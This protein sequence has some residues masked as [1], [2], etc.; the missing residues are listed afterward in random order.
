VLCEARYRYEFPSG[1]N[2]LRS[3]KPWLSAFTQRSTLR[4]TSDGGAVI[5]A[6]FG[7]QVNLGAGSVVATSGANGLV[8]K[9]DKN[10]KPLWTRSMVPS[11]QTDVLI[12]VGLSVDKEDSTYVV[13]MGGPLLD[14]N[15]LA[16][17][18]HTFATEI[19]VYKFSKSG[20]PLW[21]KAFSTWPGGLI[22]DTAVDD[23][24]QL[25]IA[26]IAH[27]QT[28]FGGGPLDPFS[29]TAYRPYLLK[30]DA[31]GRY[32]TDK[33][34][35]VYQLAHAEDRIVYV[36][37]GFQGFDL[38]WV[39]FGQNT[40]RPETKIT[41]LSMADLST[42][43][44]KPVP[45][46]STN[47]Y[48]SLL[49]Y[50]DGRALGLTS[51]RIHEN[52][53][54][55]YTRGERWSVRPI[56]ADG[57]LG[58]EVVFLEEKDTVRLD[59]EAGVVYPN[60]PDP[61]LDDATLNAQGEIAIAGYYY[62]PWTIEQL[63]TSLPHDLPL[64]DGQPRSGLPFVMKLGAQYDLQWIRKPEWGER[65]ELGGIGV[66]ASGDVWLHGQAQVSGDE[67]AAWVERDMVIT[68]LRGAP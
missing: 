54:T 33:P 48:Q 62:G 66:D 40:P 47:W 35:A 60:F 20:E 9:Y 43:W 27:A 22:M 50:P 46:D 55:T 56:A 37:G 34:N 11:L 36:D 42:T 51:E 18:S 64:E 65:P 68:K 44:A 61:W 26:G 25:F 12:P 63:G 21:R 67:G 10:C 5:V 17:V 45:S 8:H 38:I 23:D 16:A 53:E 29:L 19:V 30:L 4:N 13:G 49:G 59:D 2:V 15:P 57:T 31:Q 32:L 24:G 7:Q 52:T 3:E 39:L 28:N 14:L 58:E 6:T 41:S 1:G